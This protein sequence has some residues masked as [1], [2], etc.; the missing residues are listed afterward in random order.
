MPLSFFLSQ[1][2]MTTDSFQLGYTEEG[3]CKGDVAS[4]LPPPTRLTWDIPAEVQ[5]QLTHLLM[6]T[7]MRYTVTANGHAE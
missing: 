1:Y 2:V 7:D 4:S 6:F 5:T 3:H